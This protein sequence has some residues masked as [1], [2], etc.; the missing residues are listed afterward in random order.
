MKQPYL[1][2]SV[3]IRESHNQARP[4]IHLDPRHKLSQQFIELHHLL[5][6]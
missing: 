1:S 3:K 2:A 6:V 5:D 4:M